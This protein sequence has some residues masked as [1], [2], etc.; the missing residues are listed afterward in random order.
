MYVRDV[1]CGTT[2]GSGEPI[3]LKDLGA[4][5]LIDGNNLLGNK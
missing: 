3:V 5:A 1:K 4:T 2:K